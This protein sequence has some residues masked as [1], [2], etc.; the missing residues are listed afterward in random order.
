MGSSDASSQGDGSS[1][2]KDGA[3]LEDT[4]QDL[5]ASCWREMGKQAWGQ[6]PSPRGAGQGPCGRWSRELLYAVEHLPAS[7][8]F[9]LPESRITGAGNF[10]CGWLMPAVGDSLLS[11]IGRDQAA[12]LRISIFNLK[13]HVIE[14]YHFSY[15]IF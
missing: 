1:G 5:L 13:G 7:P 12:A 6:T 4:W 9:P 11:L 2:G 14:L 8:T 15:S 3:S 10:L